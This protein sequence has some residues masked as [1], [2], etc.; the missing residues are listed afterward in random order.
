MTAKPPQVDNPNDLIG[1]DVSRPYAQ[2][3]GK[4]RYVAN[5]TRPHIAAPTSHLSR[6]MSKPT[7]S[8]WVQAK[9]VIRYLNDTK[10]LYLIYSGDISPEH[11]F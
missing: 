4:L 2:L 3:V 1:N 11:V 10:D 8:H 6:I 7:H 9:R 5:C